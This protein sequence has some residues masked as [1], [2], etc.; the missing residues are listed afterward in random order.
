LLQK[1]F[2]E[3]KEQVQK[4][5]R[6]NIVKMKAEIKQAISSFE[7]KNLTATGLFGPDEKF[8]NISAFLG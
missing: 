8:K 5:E 4:K 7:R 2:T 3:Y 1:E 6:E